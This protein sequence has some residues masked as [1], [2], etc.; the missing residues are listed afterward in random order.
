MSDISVAEFLV[1]D[2]CDT[3]LR[4]RRIAMSVYTSWFQNKNEFPRVKEISE[5]TTELAEINKILKGLING[6]ST[7]GGG[8]RSSEVGFVEQ[9]R[10]MVPRVLQFPLYKRLENKLEFSLRVHSDEDVFIFE[11]VDHLDEKYTFALKKKFEVEEQK[12]KTKIKLTTADEVARKQKSQRGWMDYFS[13]SNLR[14]L[15]LKE[16]ASI[17]SNVFVNGAFVSQESKTVI[18]E[19]NKW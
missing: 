4:N 1:E 15:N 19:F 7:S 2:V 14:L 3:L 18:Q 10:N 9:F 11:N 6:S 12:K 16:Y 8:Y 13:K 17:L 5:S